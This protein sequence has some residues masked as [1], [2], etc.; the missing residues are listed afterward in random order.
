M[1]F[2]LQNQDPDT[3]FLISGVSP[4]TL[5]K[6]GNLCVHV[7]ACMCACLFCTHVGSGRLCDLFCDESCAGCLTF[8]LSDWVRVSECWWPF[9][10]VSGVY[11]VL[12]LAGTCHLRKCEWLNESLW[13][14]RCDGM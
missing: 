2:F 10:T 6:L 5:A 14:R 7:C 4:I 1:V 9:V 12:C 8:T 13:G 3:L 11:F